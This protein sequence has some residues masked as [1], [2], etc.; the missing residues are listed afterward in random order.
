VS[1]CRKKRSGISPSFPEG[2]VHWK[3]EKKKGGEF[4][5]LLQKLPKR[6]FSS[7]GEK[8]EALAQGGK[9]GKVY[10]WV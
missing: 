5:F 4:P 9:R 7:T 3:G 10:Y 2:S 1:G 6:V 8:K